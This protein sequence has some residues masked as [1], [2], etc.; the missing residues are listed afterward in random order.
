M[1]LPT[2]T[3]KQQQNEVAR[4][5]SERIYQAYQA[6][7]TVD[8]PVTVHTYTDVQA[9]ISWGLGRFWRSRGFRVCTKTTA[10][11]AYLSVWL[12]R[13]TASRPDGRRQRRN[14]IGCSRKRCRCGDEHEDSMDG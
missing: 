13:I 6:G 10:D 14:S 8:I 2:A 11:R 7:Q 1:R 9:K 4:E 12:E 5:F 3:P